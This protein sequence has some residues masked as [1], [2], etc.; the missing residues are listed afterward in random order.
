MIT[1]MAVSALYLA[2]WL[3]RSRAQCAETDWGVGK[4]LETKRMQRIGGGSL[5]MCSRA[6]CASIGT[7]NNAHD[8]QG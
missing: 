1:S 4:R 7:S 3:R 8:Q 6:D 5:A 2:C